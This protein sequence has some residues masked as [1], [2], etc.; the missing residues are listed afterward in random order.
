MMSHHTYVSSRIWTHTCSLSRQFG[1]VK[2]DAGERYLAIYSIHHGRLSFCL[3]VSF[4]PLPR[5]IYSCFIH[6]LG[7]IHRSQCQCHEER[8]EHEGHRALHPPLCSWWRDKYIPFSS[9]PWPTVPVLPGNHHPRKRYAAAAPPNP[10]L[11]LPTTRT[12]S[13]SMKPQHP[14]H[15]SMPCVGTMPR[16]PNVFMRPSPN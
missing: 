11:P 15:Y 16:P 8:F 14:H 7:C 5:T 3:L 10:H 12:S 6:C 9:Q 13:P 4:P 1:K 2:C